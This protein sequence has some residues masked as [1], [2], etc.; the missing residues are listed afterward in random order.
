MK[1]LLTV[2][3][4]AL[5]IAVAGCGGDTC[6]SAPAPLD[7]SDP[8]GHS[9]TLA[10]GQSITF[11]V[12]L[13]GKCT[14]SSTSCQAEFANNQIEVAPVVQ[15]CQAQQGC[16]ISGTCG[17]TTASC[18]LTIPAGVTTGTVISV[19]SVDQNGSPA[20]LTNTVQLGSGSGQCDL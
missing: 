9:C 3:V 19:Q 8:G 7:P 15:Q 6:T 18:Q 20:V 16:P 5:V 10:V 12:P 14:D 17:T 11:T 13:C 1:R 4:P 2:A